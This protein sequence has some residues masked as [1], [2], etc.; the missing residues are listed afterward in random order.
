MDHTCLQQWAQAGYDCLD[1]R[2]GRDADM[3]LLSCSSVF[4]QEGPVWAILDWIQQQAVSPITVAQSKFYF[5][6]SISANENL[7]SFFSYSNYFRVIILNYYSDLQFLKKNIP[8]SL[9][10]TRKVL[11]GFNHIENDTVIPP[12]PIGPRINKI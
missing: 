4:L 2:A 12:S 5:T 7:H 3:T 1:T 8:A 10:H 9:F 6:N 11:Y